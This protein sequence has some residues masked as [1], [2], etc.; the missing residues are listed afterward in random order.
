MPAPAFRITVGSDAASSDSF[1]P[2]SGIEPEPLGLQPSAQTNY[3]RAGCAAPWLSPELRGHQ[4]SSTLAQSAI[5]NEYCCL[6]EHRGSSRLAQSAITNEHRCRSSSSFSSVVMDP[7]VRRAHLGRWRG[8]AIA[9]RTSGIRVPVV[10][11]GAP[12][13][14]RDLYSDRESK[15]DYD[16]RRPRTG[17]RARCVRESDGDV[18]RN[19]GPKRRRATW[20]SRVALERYVSVSITSGAWEASGGT[21]IHTDERRAITALEAHRPPEL[22]ADRWLRRLGG[23]AS[24]MWT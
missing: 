3:A 17:E 9:G 8:T 1:V 7:L 4:D 13:S 24:V 22:R 15:T 20:C 16:C 18:G 21:R 5:T 6:V 2:P 11:R 10:T 19:V 12:V 14:I 23:F